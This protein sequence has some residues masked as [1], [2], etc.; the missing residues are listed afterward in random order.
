VTDQ[1]LADVARLEETV[2]REIRAACTAYSDDIAALIIEPIQG[3]GGDNHFR[4][5]FFQT[6]RRLAD[7]L[8]FLLIC[9][10]VQTGLGLTG[11]MWAWQQMGAE[12]D[13]FAFG[14]KTQVCGFASS[15]RIDDVENVFKVSSRINSTWGGNLVDMVRC[16]QYLEIIEEERLVDNAKVVG[17]HLLA[18]L[19]E[20]A[21]EFTGLVS[22]VRGRGLFIAFDLPDKALRDRTLAACLEHGLIGLASGASAI[23]FRPSL[24]LS[25][26]EANEG[27]EKLRAALTTARSHA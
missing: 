11:S 21:R 14:K 26:E 4:P 12:P 23:R 3:E 17:A 9:D 7:E 27:V 8:G 22:N 13:L 1:V 20:M 16:E 25:K 10:E 2:E 24:A 5:E 15:H 18:G 6:L 19:E